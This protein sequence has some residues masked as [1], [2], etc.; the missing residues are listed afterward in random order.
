MRLWRVYMV[1][2]LSGLALLMVGIAVTE[3]EGADDFGIL[4]V[5]E[6]WVVLCLALGLLLLLG[7]TVRR[8][9]ARLA[10]PS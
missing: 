5:T 4:L 2:S 7:R 8:L 9:V 1:L 3:V 10:K 6:Y